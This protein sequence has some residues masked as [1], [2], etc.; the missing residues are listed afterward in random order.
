MDIKNND[1]ATKNP[2]RVI[3]SKKHFIGVH[4]QM[5]HKIIESTCQL[6]K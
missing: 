1:W 2:I 4:D 6:P 3:W 5:N